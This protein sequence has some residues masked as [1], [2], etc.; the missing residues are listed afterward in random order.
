MWEHGMPGCAWSAAVE[1]AR[2]D[3]MRTEE[4]GVVATDELLPLAPAARWRPRL[5]LPGWQ[6]RAGSMALP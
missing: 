4:E 3:E 6:R 5:R 2:W 1:I